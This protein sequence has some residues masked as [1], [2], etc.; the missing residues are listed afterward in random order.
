[1]STL[2]KTPKVGGWVRLKCSLIRILPSLYRG[3]YGASCTASIGI[4][5]Y[6]GSVFVGGS[7]ELGLHF[8]I[9]LAFEF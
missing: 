3:P 2:P 9:V 5:L 6:A 8:A 7:F 1:M 4:C